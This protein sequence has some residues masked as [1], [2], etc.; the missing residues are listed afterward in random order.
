LQKDPAL[1]KLFYIFALMKILILNYEYPP[2]GGGAG[3]I[4]KHIAE[5]LAAQGNQ[6]S[7]LTTWYAGEEENT[8][9]QDGNLRIFRVK[10]LRG[11]AYKSSPRE[12]L[13]WVRHS[14]RFLN[15]HLK[16][17]HYD[18]CFANFAIPGGLVAYPLKRYFKIP[19]VIISHGHDIPWFFPKQMWFYHLMF[20]WPLRRICASAEALFVQSGS[21]LQNARRFIGKRNPEKVILIP[22]GADFHRFSPGEQAKG[23]RF[24]I[25]YSG[26]LVK[27]KGPMNFMK[28]IKE[29]RNYGNPFEVLVTGDGNMRSAMMQYARRNK[30]MGH[31]RFVGWLSKEEMPAAYR[32]AHCMIAPSLN[33]GMS[34]ATNEAL[35][36]GLYVF[37]SGVSCN[38]TLIN[39][40]VNGELININDPVAAA[41]QLDRFFRTRFLN[42]YRVPETEVKAFHTAYDWQQIVLR[43]Q[44]VLKGIIAPKTTDS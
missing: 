41:L 29:F 2:L 12:M 38:E 17:H 27:Q 5:G 8:I 39:P 7:V 3:L 24:R 20:Y 42:D 16:D 44:E 4:S 30:L 23:E 6:V 19:Y 22:N 18:L 21:M 37:V 1:L 15:I 14:R 11:S 43:Y 28:I 26:R 32:S 34:M 35:A 10:S 36:S 9:L 33:E 31:F 25:L 13:S 40:G